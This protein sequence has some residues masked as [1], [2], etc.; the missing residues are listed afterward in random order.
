MDDTTLSTAPGGSSPARRPTRATRARAERGA[1]V[2]FTLVEIVMAIVL[3]SL[4]GGVLVASLMT[5]LNAADTTSS[6]VA[7][8]IDTQLI[9]AFL[10][11]DAQAA[12]GI[13]PSTAEQAVDL[14]VSTVSDLA[15]WAGCEQAGSLVVRF[16]WIDR[17]AA[18]SDRVVVT[19]GLSP[20]GS[21]VRRACETGATTEAILGH[22]VDTATVECDP[23]RSCVGLPD[24]VTLTLAGGDER[25]P[26]DVTLS[27]SLRAELQG[28]PTTLN[29]SQVPLLAIGDATCPV[30]GVIGRGTTYVLGDAI[31]SSACGASPITGDPTLLAVTGTTS[32]LSGVNDPMADL[33]TP[34]VCR[35][36]TNPVIGSSAG[37]E[38]VTMYPTAVTISDS[39][40]FRPGRH[41]FCAGLTIASGARVTGDGVLLHVADRGVSISP[42]ATVTLTPATSGEYAGL[43]LWSAGSSDV[44]IESGASVEDLAGVVYAPDALLRISSTSGVRIGAVVADRVSIDGTG[45]TR[46]GQPSPVLTVSSATL[47]AAQTLQSYTATAPTVSG[48]TA[49]YTYR[50]TGLPVGLTM[51]SSGAITG[52]PTGSGTAT[53]SFLTIDATGASVVYTRTIDVSGTPATPTSVRATPGDTTAAVS[54]SAGTSPGAPATTGYQVT[55]TA[56]GQPTRTCTSTAPATT[57][58]LTGLVNGVTYTV[59]VVA[60]NAS[61]AGTGATATVVPIPAVLTGSNDRLWLDAADPDADGTVEG[62]AEL[63]GAGTTCATAANVLTRWEDKSGSNNDAVQSTP[64]MAG[65]FVP[66]MPA[67][68]FDA[69]GSYSATVTSGPALTAFAVAQSD[70]STWNTYGWIL[71]SRRP[72]GALIHPWPGGG[73][74]GWYPTNSGGSYLFAAETTPTSSIMTPH[75]YDITQAGSNPIVAGGALD[76]H[77]LFE[78]MSFS[79]QTRTATSVTILLGADDCCG[80]RLGN[81]KY[82]EVIVFDRALTVAER[83]SVQEYLARRWGV[84]ITPS[85]PTGV[86]TLAADRGAWVSWTAPAWNGG[87]AI[88]GYRVTAQPGGATCTAAASTTNCTV[89][90]LTNGTAYRFVVSALNAVGTGDPSAATSDTT[91]G[92]PPPP[93]SP[94]AVAADSSAAVSWTAP[95]LTGHAPLTSYTVTATASGRPTVACTASAPATSCTLS[96]LVND[97]TYSVAVTAANAHG[98]SSAVTT[99]VTPTWTPR[100]LGSSLTWWFDAA[101]STSL[102]GAWATRSGVTVSGATGG[103]RLTVSSGVVER[104]DVTTGGT[105]YTTAPTITITGGGGSG[106]AVSDQ[107]VSGGAV[108]SVMVPTRGSG[109]TSEPTVVVGGP[110]TGAQLRAR[111]MAPVAVGATIRIAGQTYTVTDRDGL[112]ITVSPALTA[113]ASAASFDE[114]QI[115]AWANRATAGAPNAQQTSAA[116]RPELGTMSGRQAVVFDG[117]DS[118]MWLLADSGASTFDH[119]PNWTILVAYQAERQVGSGAV[120]QTGSG[121]NTRIVATSG[122]GTSDWRTSENIEVNPSAGSDALDGGPVRVGGDSGTGADTFNW[123]R[124]FLGATAGPNYSGGWSFAG[125]VGEILFVDGGLDS[126]T[127]AKA[128]AYLTAKWTQAASAPSAPIALTPSAGDA[129]ATL[130]WRGANQYLSSITAYTATATA[131]GQTTRTCTTTTLTCTIAGLTNGVVYSVTVAATNATGTGPASV[132]TTVVPRPALLTSSSARFWVDGADIDGDGRPETVVDETGSST[133]AVQTWVDKSGRANHTSAPSVATRPT[134]ATQTMNGWPVITFN[135]ANILQGTPAANPYGITG[136]RTMF[137]VTRRRSG[138]PSRLV[139]RVPEDWPL[140]NL[141]ANN[142]LEVRDDANGQYQSSIG[143]NTSVANVGYVITTSRSGTALGISSNG[144]VTGSSSITGA[145]TMR[146]MTLGRHGAYG[147]TADVDIAEVALFDRALTTA[148]RRQI[149]EYLRRKWGLQLVPDIPT[150]V[151]ATQ[152]NAV[153]TV[154]WTAPASDGGSAITSYTATASPGGATCTSSTTSCTISSLTS[155]TSYTFT[156]TATNAVGAGTASAPSSSLAYVGIGAAATVAVPGAYGGVSDGTSVWVTS[157]TSASIRRIDIVTNASTTIAVGTNPAAIAWDGSS[158]WVANNGS[159]TVSRVNPATNAVLA[160]VAVASQPRGITFDGTSVWVASTS[161]TV[162]RIDPSTNAVIA[163]IAVTGNPSMI[164]SGA[165]AVWVSRL[166]GVVSRI[167]PATNTVVA[168]IT[169]GSQPY[170]SFYDGTTLWVANN[171]ANTLSRINPA[172]NTVVGT[173]TVGNGPFGL[174]SDGTRLWV[175]LS[176][177][178]QVVPVNIS[179]LAVGTPVTVGTNPSGVVFTGN[180]WVMNQ[181]SSTVSKLVV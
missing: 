15:G 110:G 103:T 13:D 42:N 74:V 21:F 176:S 115:S 7:S 136:D 152:S 57:C 108:T 172:T 142:T 148:E 41:V 3:S 105:G 129:Q 99:S 124:A 35:A 81:G 131:T 85:A 73:L 118:W 84:A 150:A 173:V 54:W 168:N 37:P 138:A 156:V 109:Y 38:T 53:V 134:A 34:A 127:V 30:L 67:V 48:G 77:S 14:G 29:S 155:G 72:S 128:Q 4:V 19:Y 97:V 114:W 158:I 139:D 28:A 11:V 122:G 92:P 140:F 113:A 94:T 23:V 52:I 146:T 130:S 44:T 65:R 55:A 43:V 6:T 96:G 119:G 10:A 75:I 12:G 120:G 1:D 56:T 47:P 163:T 36:G 121:F 177:A 76:G 170:G 123:N 162:S 165:G 93:A 88:T 31:V 18:S 60:T 87:S 2:G 112:I 147:G 5:S 39:V 125:R 117:I 149:E 49:P 111:I 141:T 137:V 89:T 64:S 166:S 102:T 51:S 82:R 22:H 106:A 61:G 180:L 174:A 178:N 86:T 135:G 68:D 71:S 169:V 161:G 78:A 144:A 16:A 154:R 107:V 91:P 100:S 95:V 66:T 40:T 159:D 24:R 58:T 98:S 143:S 45:P 9:S 62:S 181:S 132:P 20:D 70:T 167:D 171:G 59:T 116:N 101:D 46:L 33:P 145:Q 27:A 126:A 104:I 160:T 90:G 79:G 69:N 164:S 133:G 153:V 63:C 175:T 25:A 8:S 50:A 179:T 80:S 26:F 83:R 151:T 17:G 32:L 157:W